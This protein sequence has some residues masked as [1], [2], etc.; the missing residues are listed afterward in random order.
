[1]KI[2]EHPD[3]L[4]LYFS[5]HN[6]CI[7][8]LNF[9]QT[10]L[11]IRWKQAKQLQSHDVTSNVFR[12]TYSYSVEIPPICKENLVCLPIRL[13]HQIGGSSPLMIC[14]KIS[15]VIHFIDP[16]S[17]KDI[18]IGPEY[19]NHPFRYCCDRCHLQEFV[20]LDIELLGVQRGKL[21]LAEATVA[22]ASD[23]GR[24][25]ITFNTVT[26]LGNILQHGDTVAGYDLSTINVNDT[27][28]DSLKGKSLRSDVVLIKK[29]YPERRR[30][31]KK[32]HW[33]L[34]KL[35]IEAEEGHR[36][37]EQKKMRNMEEFMR[38]LEEDPEMRSQIDLFR[39]PGVAAPH[40]AVNGDMEEEGENFPEVKMEELLDAVG[41]LQI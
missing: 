6:H 34:S 14:W 15:N 2:R 19:W 41:A 28:M 39:V 10:I 36:N 18:S 24:N 32:R 25:D 1:V 9:L 37:D 16:F 22:R 8:F 30:Q 38:D 31:V 11:P 5:V 4:D 7:K 35:E 33:G 21:A 13:L 29:V 3:G 17:M 40:V 20:V 27:D 12:Y 26:H 23:L